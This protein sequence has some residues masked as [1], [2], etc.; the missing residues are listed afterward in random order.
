MDQNNLIEIRKSMGF[1][2]ENPD[3]QFVAE[4]VMD[5]LAFS[6][7]NLGY[8]ALQIKNKIEEVST[9]LNLKDIL[10]VEPHLLSGGQK[11]LVSLGAALML[12]P[13]ILIMDEG[14][15]YVDPSERDHILHILQQL[16]ETKHLTII[17]VTHDLEE[18]LYADRIIALAAGKVVLDGPSLEVYSQDKILNRLGLS[19]PFMV[20]LSL[21]LKLYGLIDHIILNMNEMVDELWK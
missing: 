21:K 20:D 10:E 12:E 16:H 13:K 18:T 11:Q 5:D 14:L 17:T 4:T 3:N 1:V 19:L 2:F 7:E 6:L 15:S 9:L 8:S